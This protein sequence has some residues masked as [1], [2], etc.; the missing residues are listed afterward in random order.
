MK[1]FRDRLGEAEN[2]CCHPGINEMNLSDFNILDP[3]DGGA[4]DCLFVCPGAVSGISRSVHLARLHAGWSV[5]DQ[6]EW[7]R[8]T[9]GLSDFAVDG[10]QRVRHFRRDGLERSEF[11]VRGPWLNVLD[12]SLAERLAEVFCI[13]LQRSWNAVAE[14]TG[15]V[16]TPDTESQREPLR[17]IILGHD[18]RSF[19]QDLFA[20]VSAAVSRLGFPVHDAGRTTAAALHEAIRRTPGV[21]GGLLVTGA[22]CPTAWAGL[23]VFDAAGESVPVVWKD[24]GIRL[25]QTADADGAGTAETGPAINRLHLDTREL[26]ETGRRLSRTSG[27]VSVLDTETGY[28]R[29]LSAW[30]VG[31]SGRS[32]VIVSDDPLVRQR[33]E[34]L[35]EL[36]AAELVLRNRQSVEPAAAAIQLLV[37]DDDRFFVMQ[38]AEGRI[39]PADLLA[40][41]LNRLLGTGFGHLT[42]HADAVTGRVWL[43]DTVL[44]TAGA[45]RG[46]AVERIEDVLAFAG[47]LLR[48]NVGGRLLV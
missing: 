20:G 32:L 25:F 10:I 1:Q 47:L 7:R 16:P 34:W 22:G 38:D 24:F 35:N 41:R 23:D 48:L 4:G 30:Y 19:S 18:A 43:T 27:P 46:S 3:A 5:C 11:G 39:Y 44:P 42:V 36:G 29:W 40:Q 37:A 17:S 26:P 21:L 2:D 6:C 9:E 15:A 33:V 45:V 14:G 28:R 13:C 31:T 12:R 8:H